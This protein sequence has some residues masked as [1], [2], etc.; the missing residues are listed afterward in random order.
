MWDLAIRY[1]FQMDQL[2]EV[3]KICS[4]LEIAILEVITERITGFPVE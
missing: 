3:K 1:K 4:E 2:Q